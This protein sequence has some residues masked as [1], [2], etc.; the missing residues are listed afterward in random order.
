V[1]SQE[2]VWP[3]KL[4]ELVMWVADSRPWNDFE[5]R[6]DDIVISTWSKSGTTWMQ[7]IVGQLI[8]NG[9]PEIYCEKLSPWL[10]F[11]LRTDGFERAA[12]QTHRRY[13][14]THLPIDA[15]VLFA[16]GEISLCRPRRARHLLELVQP[17]PEL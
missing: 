3:K 8:F 15:L 7:Q 1:I 14:K 9:D 10:D 13:L 2:I 5:F 12:A 17:P 16:Q 11:R 6:D 4:R